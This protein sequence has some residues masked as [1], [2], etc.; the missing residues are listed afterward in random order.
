LFSKAHELSRIYYEQGRYQ[1]SLDLLI[2]LDYFVED[3]PLWLPI[4]WG[5]LCCEIL[6]GKFQKARESVKRLKYKIDDYV[7]FI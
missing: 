2:E 5:K 7:Q 6:L 4:S 1:M 3:Y